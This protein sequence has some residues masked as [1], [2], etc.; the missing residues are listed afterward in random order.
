MRF[1]YSEWNAALAE[2]IRRFKSLKSL[3]NHLLLRTDGDVD[4]SCACSVTVRKCSSSSA[5][6]ATNTL[7][8]T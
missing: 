8:P 3:F 5:V 2:R 6:T 1:R 4:L 7:S